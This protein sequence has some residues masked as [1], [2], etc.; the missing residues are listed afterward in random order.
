MFV[1]MGRRAIVP[2]AVP[3]KRRS[4]LQAL[5]CDVLPSAAVVADHGTGLSK[6]SASEQFVSVLR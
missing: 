4:Q 3:S 5:V 2:T 6:R 1:L